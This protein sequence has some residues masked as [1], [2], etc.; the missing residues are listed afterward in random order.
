MMHTLATTANAS[1]S[2]VMC[3]SLEAQLVGSHVALRKLP[4][5]AQDA[6]VQLDVFRGAALTLFGR[7]LRRARA[8]VHFL[9]HVRGQVLTR[10]AVPLE[11]VRRDHLEAP[12][13][14]AAR[15]VLDV[16]VEIGV[17]VFPDDTRQRSLEV[18]ALAAVELDVEAMVRGCRTRQP[19]DTHRD[20]SAGKPDSHCVL[21]F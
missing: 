3:V 5:D 15:R 17:R 8:R 14:G 9:P 6:V 1:P 11:R 12:G 19:E 16:H 21:P 18:E 13:D 7:D 10:R 4:D 20:Y 2:R